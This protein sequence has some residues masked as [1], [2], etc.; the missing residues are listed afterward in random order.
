MPLILS[1]IGPDLVNPVSRGHNSPAATVSKNTIAHASIA[2]DATT[3]ANTWEMTNRTVE[4]FATRNTEP[5]ETISREKSSR[6]QKNSKTT[7]IVA[8]I[9]W[10]T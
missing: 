6:N 1:S 10:S 9:H 8:W 7:R 5:S 3:K 4:A 2:L